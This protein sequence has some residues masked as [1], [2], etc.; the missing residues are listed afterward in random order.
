MT[1]EKTW[2]ER[3]ID[4]RMREYEERIRLR[5]LQRAGH[6]CSR[7][8]GRWSLFSGHYRS[9]RGIEGKSNLHPIL[10]LYPVAVQ[11]VGRELVSE[12]EFPC[13]RFSG[14]GRAEVAYMG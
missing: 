1:A 5:E 12:R 6:S 13:T 4:E 8:F 2:L 7:S 9:F 14:A 11:A 10:S 3:Y